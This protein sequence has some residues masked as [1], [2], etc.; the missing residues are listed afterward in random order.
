MSEGAHFRQT[1]AGQPD[2]SHTAILYL[3]DLNVSFDGFKA[4]NNLTLYIDVG[5]LRCIIGPNG[6]GKTTMMDIITG[7]T[8]PDSGQAWFGQTVDLLK[9]SEPEIANAGIGRKF[10]KPT[11]F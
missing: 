5:E 3:E 1:V 7:K 8:R 4:I 9:L 11:V 10:K 2:A 6:A